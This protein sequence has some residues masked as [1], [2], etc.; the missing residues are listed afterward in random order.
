MAVVADTIKINKKKDYFFPA[1]KNY[2][3]AK[4]QS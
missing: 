2:R 4:M 3:Q 1:Q